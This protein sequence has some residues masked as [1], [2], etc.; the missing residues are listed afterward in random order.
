MACLLAPDCHEDTS[1][2]M[3][4]G[5][6]IPIECANRTL[7]P[8]LSL[9][10][11]DAGMTAAIGLPLKKREGTP[12]TYSHSTF[13]LKRPIHLQSRALQTN[14]EIKQTELRLVCRQR[15]QTYP[16][17]EPSPRRGCRTA[18]ILARRCSQR[19]TLREVRH[20]PGRSMRSA[21]APVPCRTAGH[22]RRGRELAKKV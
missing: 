3:L 15:P 9:F 8:V 5:K 14:A 16:T 21:V 22:A 19:T 7:F 2:H 11:A 1:L 13:P 4:F 10:L 6:G 17:G 20:E 18:T 12:L